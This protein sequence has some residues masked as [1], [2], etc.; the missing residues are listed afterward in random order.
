MALSATRNTKEFE[1]IPGISPLNLPVYS[2]AKLYAGAIGCL[3]STGYVVRGSTTTGL[4][5]VGRV[6]ALADNTGGASGAIKVNVKPGV[7]WWT[8]S[9]GDPIALG[10]VGNV[11]YIEDDG[12]VSKTDG[13]GTQSPAG[14][15]VQYDSTLGVAVAMGFGMLAPFSPSTVTIQSGTSTLVNGTKQIT[16]AT[17]T[18]NSRIFITMRDPGSGALTDSA[19]FDVPVGTRVNGAPGTFVVNMIQG[20]DKAT[21]ATAVSTFDWLVIN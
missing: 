7:Y 2:S 15:I 1:V 10:D 5:V 21:L 4:K 9:S 8:N 12:T 20:A 6:E 14:I 11:C 19:G 17:I 16:T 3:N 18:S 13:S